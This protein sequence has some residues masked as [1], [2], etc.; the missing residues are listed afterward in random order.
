MEGGDDNVGGSGAGIGGGNEVNGNW[1]AR[2]DGGDKAQMQV[3]DR[4]IV[5]GV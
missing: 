2:R 1:R 4:I 3:P 5:T